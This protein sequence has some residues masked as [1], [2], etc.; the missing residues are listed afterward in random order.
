MIFAGVVTATPLLLFAGAARRLR[1]VVL[2][3]TQF[4]AP[5]L[6]FLYGVLILH[7]QMT[8]GRWVGFILVWISL[9]ILSVDGLLAARG[10]RRVSPVAV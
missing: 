10:A 9:V 3:L 5:V 6:Q 2:G 8:P 1:L 7:E 4:L